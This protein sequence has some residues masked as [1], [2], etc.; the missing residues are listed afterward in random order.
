MILTSHNFAKSVL[1]LLLGFCAITR[2]QKGP[3]SEGHVDFLESHLPIIIIDTNGREIVDSPRIVAGM[4]VIDNGDAGNKM[5]DT[6][7]AYDGRI[8]IE[9]RGSSSSRYPKKQYRL[10]TQDENGENLNVK[11]LGMPKENDWILY[12]PYDDESLIRNALAYKWSNEIGRYAA[13]TAF[14]EVVLNDDYRGVYLFVEKIKRDKNRIDIA[15]L[16]EDDV[17]GDSLTG[18]YILK[19]D[20]RAGEN[21]D[22]WHS[23]NGIFYQYDYPK[24]GDILPQQQDYIQQFMNSFESAMSADWTADQSFLDVLDIDSAVD[25]FLLNELCKNVDAYRI[26]AFM[27]KNRDDKNGRL[28]LGP[29]WDMN[30]SMGKA[31][32]RDDDGVYEGWQVDYRL[33]RPSD[34]LQPP[35]WWEKLAH[36]PIFESLAQ[37]RW[38]ELRRTTFQQDS[39]F[40]D[41]DSFVALLGDA[42]D[43]NFEKWPGVLKDGETFEA[44][45]VELKQWLI[46]RLAWVD[47]HLDNLVSNAEMSVASVSEFSLAQ[48][49]PNPFNPETTIVFSIPSPG[50]VRLDVYNV[51][52][53]RVA[54]LVNEKLQTGEHVV[55]WDAGH[56]P[57]GF[58]FYTLRLKDQLLTR[59]MLLLK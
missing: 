49:Y 54:A 9:L 50:F 30:L 36:D 4:K 23:A 14:C 7:Y 32:F 10:E 19:I 3:V 11:L 42:V 25:H 52:G 34:G 35:F 21:N 48:N 20:K 27:Y 24:P 59:Q 57:S 29:I 39:L 28:V 17:A 33:H 56:S 6:N 58:Y 51:I 45:I 41:I 38:N 1:I 22:G 47:A 5:T 43:R 44:K 13:R 26:S 18:G 31:W 2:A 55:S 40:A 12:G 8:E 37:A 46:N 53:R 15:R 16:D